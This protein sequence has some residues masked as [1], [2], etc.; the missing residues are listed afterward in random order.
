MN[1]L[2]VFLARIAFT[3]CL[4]IYSMSSNALATNGGMPL[5]PREP[6]KNLREAIE[7]GDVLA[8][9]AMI[10]AMSQEEAKVDLVVQDR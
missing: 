1:L 10:R 7:A 9:G 5:A 2:Y 6:P 3:S 8:V 4:A